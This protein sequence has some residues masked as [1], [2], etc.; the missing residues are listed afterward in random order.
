M[1]LLLSLGSSQNRLP[2][3]LQQVRR[4]LDQGVIFL[5]QKAL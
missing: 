1:G 5:R 3:S 4:A 2:E